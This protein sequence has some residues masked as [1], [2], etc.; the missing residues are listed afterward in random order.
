MEKFLKELIEELN[1]KDVSGRQDVEVMG[2]AC[3]SRKVE[4][5]FLFVCVRGFNF[6]GHMFT[7]E[8]I[9]KGACALVVEKDIEP[10]D[11][12]TI[13]K[14]PSSRF[15]LGLLGSKFYNWPSSKLWVVGITG[16]NG[17]TTTTYLA[18]KILSEAG[19]KVALFGTIAY[20]LGD[21]VLPASTTTPQSL[22]L[23]SMFKKLVE[24]GFESVV[25]E[26]SSHALALDR[27]V[28]CEFDAGVF[29]N[30][31]RDHLDFHK[32][33][34]NYL[35][36]KTK[37]FRLLSQPSERYKQKR[38]IINIDDP[39]ARHIIKNT[40]VRILTYGIIQEANIRACDISLSRGGSKFNVTTPLGKTNIHLQLPGEHNIYN[41]LAAIGVGISAGIN[42]DKIREAIANLENIPGRF[43]R[44][45]YGQPFSVIVDYAHTPDAL[46]A[47]LKT[48][49][50]LSRSKVL[51]VF[52]CGGNRD[53]TKRSLM[54]EVAANYGDIIILTSDNPRNED[55]IKIIKEIEAGIKKVKPSCNYLIIEN[56]REAIEEALNLAQ[57]GDLV[58]VA[59]KGHEDYQIIKDRRVPFSD[60]EVVG[61]ILQN[62]QKVKTPNSSLNIMQ[63]EMRE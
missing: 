50:E 20:Q 59:G 41:A 14:V 42:L 46:G 38:A 49:R 25:M 47:V 9:K 61:K 4:K 60:K 13:V 34:E 21:K 19:K 32:T 51:V 56:R 37:L 58:L 45:E 62:L 11:G 1:D 43:E 30:L 31:G 48:A 3:D 2:V 6:D 28:G 52:G 35:E 36:A 18:R 17:K 24:D 27:V 54:G 39:Y 5:G 26:V 44:I 23:Q 63:K 16:T 53:K 7:K 57:N 22:E 8:A 15:A 33:I 29:T 12:I 55:P 10:V 40:K